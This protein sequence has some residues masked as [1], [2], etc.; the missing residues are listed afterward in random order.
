MSVNRVTLLGTVCQRPRITTFEDGGRVANVRMCTEERG[1]TTAD[2]R[3]IAG[4]KE[5]HNLVIHRPGVIDYIKDNV[6]Q[7]DSIYVEGKMR[8]RSY[9][10]EDD[11]RYITEVYVDVL[12]YLGW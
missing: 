12:E 10:D 2:G 9:G 3:E 7:H 8:T 5:Y 1:Y 4:R 6:K 11:K